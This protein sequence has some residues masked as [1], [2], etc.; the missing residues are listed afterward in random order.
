MLYDDENTMVRGSTAGHSMCPRWWCR[1]QGTGC[2]FSYPLKGRPVL[3]SLT[4][5]LQ[6][7]LDHPQRMRAHNQRRR[8][9][10]S[11]ATA[12][13][14]T[15]SH[16]DKEDLERDLAL[17]TGP[18]EDWGTYEEVIAG[19]M[20]KCDVSIC[21]LREEDLLQVQRAATATGMMVRAWVPAKKDQWTRIKQGLLVA[22]WD[23]D[24]VQIAF[25][26]V[27]GH[28]DEFGFHQTSIMLRYYAQHPVSAEDLW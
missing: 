17:C 2:V 26:D 3:E 24:N 16:N 1:D 22:G 23:V 19:E 25:D 9:S 10:Q 20:S 21:V 7:R 28:L 8:S 5:M 6:T 27:C 12:T 18:A 14:D 13:D 4:M 11:S 15:A